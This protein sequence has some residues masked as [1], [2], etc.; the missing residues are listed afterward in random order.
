[1]S[2][3]EFLLNI[4]MRS[5]ASIIERGLRAVG[6]DTELGQTRPEDEDE[7]R[8]ISTTGDL[9]TA[10]YE[11]DTNGPGIV[12]KRLQGPTC[13]HYRMPADLR[14]RLVR[15]QEQNQTVRLLKWEDLALKASLLS[16]RIVFSRARAY[17]NVLC[18]VITYNAGEEKARLERQ[19]G[20]DLR[21]LEVFD[22]APRDWRGQS[23]RAL[24]KPLYDDNA[25]AILRDRGLIHDPNYLDDP[26]MVHGSSRQ[27]SRGDV[28]RGPI[29]Y[30]I[31]Q[32]K[33]KKGLKEQ[34]NEQFRDRHPHLPPSLTF[35]KIRNL[36]KA[37][38]LGCLALDIEVTTAAF[39][40]VCFER[41]CLK[42][43]V[44]KINRYLT[45]SVCLVLAYKFLEPLTGPSDRLDRLMSFID[46]EWEVSKKEVFEAEFGAFVQLGFLLHLPY[47]HIYTVYNKMLKLVHKSNRQYLGEGMSHVYSTDISVLEKL[48]SGAEEVIE[49]DEDFEEPRTGEAD[50]GDG[51]AEDAVTQ[52]D[53]DDVVLSSDNRRPFFRKNSFG[54]GAL[55]V[56][57]GGAEAVPNKTEEE[58]PSPITAIGNIVLGFARRSSTVIGEVTT[59]PPPL[60]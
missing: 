16:S 60:L 12:G 56:S 28:K 26:K 49:E 9:P 46:R 34:L 42:G 19:S 40:F 10:Q 45:M 11:D 2:A 18:T 35:S 39:A 37:L 4:S 32:F 54:F 7:N 8:S 48:E 36:K 43:V 31:I 15:M 3:L 1:L 59:E 33:N 14:Y 21:S 50:Y 44:N 57:V 47:Q 29:I 6:E 17:P 24:L 5:E 58:Q 22:I 51:A 25:S 20:A 38:L 13:E 41:L 23:Y 53:D 55:L 52:D 30:S 27:E